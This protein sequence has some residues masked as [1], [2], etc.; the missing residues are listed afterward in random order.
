M[1]KN[2]Q[3]SVSEY[4]ERKAYIEKLN[5]EFE[6]DIRE[7]EKE[8]K[9][10]KK[11]F[12]GFKVNVIKRLRRNL[13]KYNVDLKK[14][15]ARYNKSNILVIKLQSDVHSK[16]YTRRKVQSVANEI[17]QMLNKYG[18][19]GKI[20]SVLKYDYDY[21]TGSIKE[22]GDDV[23][24]YQP[25][26]YDQEE[27]EKLYDQKYFKNFYIN[28][29]PEKETV[30]RTSQNNDCLYLCL[31]IAL[32]EDNP[33]KHP[34]DL[35]AFLKVRLD[36]GIDISLI[37]KLEDKLMKDNIC[38]NVSGDHVYTSIYKTNKVVNLKLINGHYTID[39]SKSRKFMM[40]NFN[41]KPPLI[42]DTKNM[43]VLLD[44]EIKKIDKSIFDTLKKQYMVIKK[45]WF[46]DGLTF[47]ECY[48][49]FITNAE[50]LKHHSNGIINLYK[51]GD[52]ISKIVLDVFDYFTKIIE[53]PQ[54]ISQHETEFLNKS[55]QGSLIFNEKY[56]GK[57]YK[58]D[59]I[60]M[61]P[62]IMKSQF[63]IPLKQGE[64][65][66]LTDE[67]FNKFKTSFFPYGIYRAKINK[68][69][70]DNINRLFRFDT[71]NYY[72]HFSLTH[73]KKLGLNIELIQDDQPNLLF[74][75]RDKCITGNELFSKY[76]D[77]L[78]D[79]KQKNVPLSK[80]IL[81]SLWGILCETDQIKTTTDKKEEE[82]EYYYNDE[83]DTEI[84]FIKPSKI[85][86]NE[87][88]IGYAKNN[89]FFKT[90]FARMK[91]FLLSK[92]RLIISDIMQ[93]YYKDLVIRCHTDGFLLKD[94]PEN[95]KIGDKLGD[96]KYEGY[97]N[98]CIVKNNLKEQGDLIKV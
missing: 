84:T 32:G 94:K 55:T 10:V 12:K 77:L 92:A 22:I 85:N 1:T 18:V 79:L 89:K 6:K 75:S 45:S 39:N 59:I 29:Y 86:E 57:A 23:N 26:E 35:K 24:L 66:K 40:K 43:K 88:I 56:Q 30:G 71:N 38:I 2:L 37:P 33:F 97:Y 93:P 46:K 4:L 8:E 50:Q 9:K 76:I 52:S 19:N 91:P 62:S 78:Y 36:D 70:D 34:R 13:E 31:Q 44:G 68:S 81:N 7:Y 25:G 54:D 95:I 80:K 14:I 73:A 98:E 21:R 5:E 87:F 58:Y 61:Y 90:N 42:V 41:N 67:E 82:E 51:N 17:S 28:V 64:F 69:E 72:T 74:Y 60:S 15:N 47:E 27:L 53:I 48:E 83:E 65:K 49:E 63:L 96:L 20:Q 11:L 3:Q 16:G